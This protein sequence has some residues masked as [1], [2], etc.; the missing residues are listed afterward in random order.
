MLQ[1]QMEGPVSI[2]HL[3]QFKTVVLMHWCSIQAVLLQLQVEGLLYYSYK[4]S[5][6]C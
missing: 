1:L 5:G 4:Q 2:R 6:E 3:W